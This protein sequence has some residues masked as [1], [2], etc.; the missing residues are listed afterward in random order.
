MG[1]IES[2]EGYSFYEQFD[3][4]LRAHYLKY[5]A[6]YCALMHIFVVEV[7]IEDV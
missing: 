6:R 4:G 1:S 2:Y 5:F 3:G 7:E